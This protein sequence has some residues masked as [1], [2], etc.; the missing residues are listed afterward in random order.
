[1][2]HLAIDDYPDGILIVDTSTLQIRNANT[3]AAELFRIDK[4]KISNFSLPELL[5]GAV[6][7]LSAADGFSLTYEIPDGTRAIVLEISMP[8]R[9]DSDNPHRPVFLREMTSHYEI[10]RDLEKKCER[11]R[12][13]DKETHHRVKN[14]LAIVSSLIGL[15]SVDFE[16]AKEFY[17]LASQVE[18][19]AEIHN[20][21][22]RK[23]GTLRVNISSYLGKVVKSALQA[24][25]FLQLSPEINIEDREIPA[26]A[27]RSLGIIVNEIIINSCKYG[28]DPET[29]SGA[30]LWVELSSCPRSEETE[31]ILRIGNNGRFNTG[32]SDPR[33]SSGIGR[34][35]IDAL[36]REL[37]ASIRVTKEPH[38]IFEIR[39]TLGDE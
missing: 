29:R 14:S 11:L 10:R 34:T 19:V 32:T 28:F 16:N 6:S 18:A 25:G 39:L 35:L 31:L 7:A 26:R 13:L 36:L 20:E 33:H 8:A 24:Y 38:P 30:M 1:M 37:D 23:P 3:R 15:K 2:T 17:H 27:A 4:E 12:L 21:L 9:K 5:P 22:A